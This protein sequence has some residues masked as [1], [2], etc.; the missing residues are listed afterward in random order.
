MLKSE[1]LK[2]A[3]PARAAAAPMRWITSLYTRRELWALFLGCAFPLHAWAII[4]ALRDVSWVAERTNMSDAVGVVSYGLLFALL[5]SVLLFAVML[6]LGA[7]ISTRWDA[8]HRVA[9]LSALALLASIWAALEQ[10][11]FIAGR[12]LPGWL[13]GFLIGSGHPLRTLYMVLI[14]VLAL[15][16]GVPVLLVLGTRRGFTITRAVME[17]LSLLTMFYLLLDAAGILIVIIRNL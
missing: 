14:A 12:G 3:T 9:A 8:E 4:L 5:E 15:T 10:G 11:F 13:I 16:I 1:E 6:V 2:G 17:R 7:L